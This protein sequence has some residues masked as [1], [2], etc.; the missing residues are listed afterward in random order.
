MVAFSSKSGGGISKTKAFFDIL[1][2]DYMGAAIFACRHCCGA[3]MRLAAALKWL[4][5]ECGL[6]VVTGKHGKLDR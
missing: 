5:S 3:E 4:F 6:L 2:L 1:L